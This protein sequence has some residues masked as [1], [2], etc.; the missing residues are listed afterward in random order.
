MVA[1]TAFGFVCEDSARRLCK[2]TQ[3]EDSLRRLSKKTESQARRVIPRRST[4]TA[5]GTGELLKFSDGWTMLGFDS[6]W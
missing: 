1:I 4:A 5:L 6:T 3:Q 2:R